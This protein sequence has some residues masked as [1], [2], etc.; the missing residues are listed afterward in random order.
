MS[1]RVEHRMGVPAPA[2]VI[3]EVLSDLPGWS[4]WNPIYPKIEDV[5]KRQ[6]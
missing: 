2:S 5:Y 6:I 1:F 3:W 4:A